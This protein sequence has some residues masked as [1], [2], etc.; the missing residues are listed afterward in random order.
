MF[1]LLNILWVILDWSLFLSSPNKDNTNFQILVNAI[2]LLATLTTANLNSEIVFVIGM[3]K[4]II[5]LL[6]SLPMIV[7]A[8]ASDRGTSEYKVE[9]TTNNSN[10]ISKSENITLTFP[11]RSYNFRNVAL[12]PNFVQEYYKLQNKE[13]RNFFEYVIFTFLKEYFYFKSVKS[14]YIV[15]R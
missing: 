8:N 10:S 11:W 1:L 3:S 6:V 2:L 7:M 15:K 14:Y 4:F 12:N 5:N 13:K 9:N